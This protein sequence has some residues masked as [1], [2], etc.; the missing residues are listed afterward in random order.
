MTRR[1]T[2]KLRP[3]NSREKQDNNGKEELERQKYV[4]MKRQDRKK[5]A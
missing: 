1:R 4:K 5:Q 3:K 2:V